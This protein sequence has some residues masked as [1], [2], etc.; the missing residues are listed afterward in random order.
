MA[1]PY[2][3]GSAT[4]S[5][6]LSQ[7]DSNF[8]TAITLGNTA[9][10]LGNTITNL[11][12]VS[13][14]ASASSLSL[15]TSGNTTAVTID[16]SQN[17]GIGTASPSYKLDVN[18]GTSGGAIR[19]YNTANTN[20]AYLRATNS[21]SSVQMGE[22]GTGGFVEQ[23][24]AYPLRFFTNNTEAM[25]ITSAGNLTFST[26]NAGIVFNNSSALVNSTLNDYETGSW[27]PTLASLTGSYTSVTYG[28]QYGKYTKIGNLVYAMFDISTTAQVVGTAG[29]DLLIGGFPFTMANSGTSDSYTGSI[30]YTTG[31][32]TP[33]S[34][35][36][37]NS[38][39]NNRV[40]IG[41]TAGGTLA[42]SSQGATGFGMR[43]TICY[44]AT[45]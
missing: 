22:D 26:S 40:Y 1:V 32:V 35:L 21:Q 10:Q 19:I 30:G 20:T 14:L 27:T 6:P 28:R 42:V 4:T 2:T 24:G 11:T 39:G 38:S 33:C 16:T 12:G 18:A 8:A 37:Q 7:L 34:G 43:A 3:F 13:N 25:R 23:L 17:V 29:S 31:V 5:I 44:Q 45:F 15:G 9:V 41:I 36:L